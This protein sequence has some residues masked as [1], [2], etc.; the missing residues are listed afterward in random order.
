MLNVHYTWG[1]TLDCTFRVSRLPTATT[2]DMAG[3]QDFLKDRDTPVMSSK[4][5]EAEYAENE[6]SN[7]VVICYSN[8]QTSALHDPLQTIVVVYLSPSVPITMMSLA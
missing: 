2:P 1:F 7:N 6:K 8:R 4:S 5:A 3:T